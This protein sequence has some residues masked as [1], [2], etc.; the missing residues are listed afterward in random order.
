MISPDTKAIWE[1]NQGSQRL[2]LSCPIRECLLEG[3]RGGGKTDALLMDFAQHVGKGY[4]AEWRGILFRNT[5]PQLEDV[6]AKSRRWFPQMFPRVRFNGGDYYWRWPTGEMLFFRHFNVENDYWNYHGHEY[7][8]IGWE[9]LT[10]WPDETCY[11]SMFACNRSSHPLV[12][13]VIRSTTNPYGRGHNWVK[14]RFIDPKPAGHVIADKRTIPMFKDGELVREEVEVKRIRLHSS[15]L[16]NPKLL[17]ADP[18]YL[19]NIEGVSNEAKRR[20][21]LFGDWSVNAGGMFDDVWYEKV[22]VLEPFEIPEGWRIDRSFD[23]GSSKPFSVGWW[24]ESDGSPAR[25]KDGSMRHF[26]RGSLFRIGEWYGWTGKPNEGLKMLNVDIA[27]GVRER[28]AKMGIASRV[29]RGPADSMIF[30]VVNGT[31]IADEMRSRGVTWTPA[32]K[33]KGS[34][35][36][37]WERMR[38]YLQN[39]TDVPLEE[40]GMWIFSNCRQFIRTVPSLPRD[41]K[42]MDD[43]DTSQEDHVADES[44]YRV[45]NKARG[46]SQESVTH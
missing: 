44:R 36:N 9:E 28:E 6:V 15:Y 45:M 35:V 17:V 33:T 40:P 5:Y 13:R 32:D 10:N 1:P 7:P 25:L 26:P 34:R 4:G 46:I 41:E 8:W 14:L 16:E 22:H 24:A 30:D 11:D 20:A 3:T 19:A 12:P 18:F 27:T 42:N 23:W 39:A 38:V 2:F 29:M 43:I 21:W 37:G 31:S